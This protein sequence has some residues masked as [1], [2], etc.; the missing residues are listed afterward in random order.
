M[1]FYGF[2][3]CTLLD[4][5]GEVAATLFVKDCNFRCPFCHN[6][7]LVIGTDKI[8]PLNTDDIFKYLEKRRNVLGGVCITGGEPFLCDELPEIINKIHELGLKVKVDTNGSRPEMFAKIKV[9]CIAMDIK[10]S[11]EKY[12]LI[13][14]NGNGDIVGL[15][16]KSINYL[17]SSDLEYRFRTTVVPGIVEIDDIKKIVSVI[18]GAKK[19]ILAQFRPHNTLISEF[20]KV[21]PYHSDVLLE[22]KTIV[23][24]AGVPCEVREGY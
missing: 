18:K 23:E 11:F 7:E 15:L 16:K 8:F 3:K 5:P 14:Y 9:D 2:Q 6:K 1:Q 22:M 17:L 4:F 24:D 13:K 20:E 12:D 10:T 21:M 19:Y